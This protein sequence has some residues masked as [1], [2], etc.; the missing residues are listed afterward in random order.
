MLVQIQCLIAQEHA[1][2]QKPLKRL[3]QG[4]MGVDILGMEAKQLRGQFLLMT[5]HGDCQQFL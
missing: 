5:Y 2:E 4:Q 3:V 1:L